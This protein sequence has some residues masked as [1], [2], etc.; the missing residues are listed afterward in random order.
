MRVT[1]SL[2][3]VKCSLE[4]IYSADGNEECREYLNSVRSI[5]DT[6]FRFVSAGGNY[7][8]DLMLNSLTHA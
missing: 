3:N 1:T 7:L 4:I 6:D 2:D 8:I 5:I